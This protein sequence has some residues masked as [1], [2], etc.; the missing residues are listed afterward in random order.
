MLAGHF[1][2]GSGVTRGVGDVNCDGE[3]DVRD[4]ADLM[5][6]FGCGGD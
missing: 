2:E 3:V 6:G 4:F 1:G 5:G